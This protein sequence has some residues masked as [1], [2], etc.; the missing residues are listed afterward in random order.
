MKVMILIFYLHDLYYVKS[1]RNNLGMTEIVP[2]WKIRPQLLC[3]RV[4]AVMKNL[5]LNLKLDL[6]LELKVNC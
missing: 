5:F 3:G 1:I 2:H 6:F 4:D